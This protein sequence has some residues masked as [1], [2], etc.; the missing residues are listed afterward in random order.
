MCAIY[1]N[2]LFVNVQ[3]TICRATSTTHIESLESKLLASPFLTYVYRVYSLLQVAS[4]HQDRL[5]YQIQWESA[6][7]VEYILNC[8]NFGGFKECKIRISKAQ[9]TK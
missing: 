7:P 4:S 5:P 9:K 1:F 8:S 3:M 6:F 2:F